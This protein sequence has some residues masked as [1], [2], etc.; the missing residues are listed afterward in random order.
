VA[1]AYDRLPLGSLR[2]FEAVASSL[3]FTAAAEALHVTTAAVSQQIKT[4]EA[5]V[6]VP[7]FRRTGRRVEITAEGLELLPSVRAGLDRLE[8]AVQQL[9]RYRRSGPMQISLIVSFLQMWLL[10]RLRSF[11]RKHPDIDLRFHTSREMV[12]FSRTEHHLAIRF[13]RG[14]YANLYVEKLMDEWLVPVAS[15]ELIKQHGMIDRRTDLGKYP[16]LNSDTESWNLWSR[17][18]EEAAWRSGAPNID[19]SAGILAAAEEGLG[20]ALARWTL[21]SLPLQRG[22]LRLAGKDVLPFESAYYFV[23]PKP[24]LELPKVSQFRDW[25]FAAARDFPRPAGRTAT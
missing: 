6:Q 20:F 23:C 5:Y 15:P 17:P 2:V 9:K 11:R 25:I 8:S 7:L 19:D 16:L 12:D 1:P 13:G 21:V 10:P 3:S 24:F 14:H 22:T 18:G 4:L